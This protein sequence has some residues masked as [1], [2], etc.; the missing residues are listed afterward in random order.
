MVRQ[1]TGKVGVAKSNPTGGNFCFGVMMSLPVM[2]S[3]SSLD[4]TTPRQHPPDSTPQTAPPG[5]HHPLDNTSS[6]TPKTTPKPRQ[7]HPLHSST[8]WTA[9]PPDSTT[10]PGQYHSSL[11]DSITPWTAPPPDSTPFPVNKR[12][13]YIL[14]ECF[15]VFLLNIDQV[16]SVPLDTEYM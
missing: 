13:V 10:P 2:D 6:T 15:L 16:L 1:W 14:L 3:T 5:Q 11:P 4:S 8:P 9:P 12:V 7:N